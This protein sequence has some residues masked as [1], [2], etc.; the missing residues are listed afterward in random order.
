MFYSASL[1]LRQ[2]THSHTT[3]SDDHPDLIGD[4]DNDSQTTGQKDDELK[5]TPVDKDD[6]ET[7]N[8]SEII[9]ATSSEGDKNESMSAKTSDTEDSANQKSA[10]DADGTVLADLKSADDADKSDLAN[11]KSADDA[12]KPDLA[13]STEDGDEA[14]MA[15]RKSAVDDLAHQKS[16]QVTDQ[17][18]TE[19]QAGHIFLPDNITQLDTQQVS[20]EPNKELKAAD[21][22][23]K[24]S[25]DEAQAEDNIPDSL[26]P[27]LPDKPAQQVDEKPDSVLNAVDGFVELEESQTSDEVGGTEVISPIDT[28]VVQSADNQDVELA[29]QPSKESEAVDETAAVQADGEVIASMTGEIPTSDTETDDNNEQTQPESKPDDIAIQAMLANLSAALMQDYGD[30][31]DVNIDSPSIVHESHGDTENEKIECHEASILSVGDKSQQLEVYPKELKLTLTS[32]SFDMSPANAQTDQ[33]E[34]VSVSGTLPD[35]EI[36]DSLVIGSE[37]AVTKED[38]ENISKK[39]PAAPEYTDKTH[40]DLKQLSTE[41]PDN[42]VEPVQK[43]DYD[44][45]DELVKRTEV[46]DIPNAST[47]APKGT[48]D[49][50]PD[51]A[52]TTSGQPSTEKTV[53]AVVEPSCDHA[54]VTSKDISELT[55]EEEVAKADNGGS[56]GTPMELADSD[57]GDGDDETKAEYEDIYDDLYGELDNTAATA[58]TGAA[59]G[60]IAKG[61]IDL[62]QQ[63]AE[64]LFDTGDGQVYG[65][66]D[67]NTMA[68]VI[69][70]AAYDD[71]S[72]TGNSSQYQEYVDHS[73][74]HI[75][76][77]ETTTAEAPKLDNPEIDLGLQS[78]SWPPI[79]SNQSLT[80]LATP[81]TIQNPPMSISFSSG[82][83]HL[84]AAMQRI[85]EGEAPDLP[86]SFAYNPT[87]T[88]SIASS[89]ATTLSAEVVSTANSISPGMVLPLVSPSKVS[90]L[91]SPIQIQASTANLAPAPPLPSNIARVL[92]LNPATHVSSL[93][94]PPVP[95]N[96]SLSAPLTMPPVPPS[97]TAM[98]SYGTS[99]LPAPPPFP[100]MAAPPVMPAFVSAVGIS[101]MPTVSSAHRL[102][103]ELSIPL[104]PESIPL[105]PENSATPKA[106]SD[107]RPIPLPAYPVAV[108]ESL[109]SSHVTSVL[110]NSGDLISTCS[111]A[112]VTVTMAVAGTPKATSTMVSSSLKNS[113]ISPPLAAKNGSSSVRSVTLPTKSKSAQPV[114]IA[115][116]FRSGD[117]D[118]KPNTPPSRNESPDIPSTSSNTEPTKTPE[119]TDK[120]VSQSLPSTSTDLK[121]EVLS[122][123]SAPSILSQIA[124]T[125]S[126]IN[127]IVYT[128][129]AAQPTE[130]ENSKRSEKYKPRPKSKQAEREKKRKE[131]DRKSKDESERPSSRSS[132]HKHKNKSEKSHSEAGG[133]TSKQSKESR[134]GFKGDELQKLVELPKDPRQRPAELPRDP[135]AKPPDVVKTAVQE[136]VVQEVKAPNDAE[137]NLELEIA[138]KSTDPTKISSDAGPSSKL[139]VAK[140]KSKPVRRVSIDGSKIDTSATDIGELPV[141]AL[142]ARIQYLS[143]VMKGRAAKTKPTTVTKE[144]VPA[145]KA[146]KVAPGSVLPA[147]IQNVL[148]TI[149][150]STL[151]SLKSVITGK[152][153][154]S[155]PVIAAPKKIMST[156]PPELR[157]LKPEESIEMPQPALETETTDKPKL[158]ETSSDPSMEPVMPKCKPVL[159]AAELAA[160]AL[161]EAADREHI[162]ASR[163]EALFFDQVASE[164][165]DQEAST[166]GCGGIPGLTVKLGELMHLTILVSK[167][168]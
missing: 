65:E 69:H 26:H 72:L 67:T 93:Q 8:S 55:V 40:T 155:L 61:D 29:D 148:K 75:H 127:T 18:K 85:V 139:E 167:T 5:T 33:G 24:V 82:V 1:L 71:H 90:A 56:G 83:V 94:A 154:T 118:S 78:T 86:V 120:I 122:I 114:G 89:T 13:K 110:N 149:T 92:D 99:T 143:Q 62:R 58:S 59:K 68:A 30:K 96:I 103:I 16:N 111:D 144:Q 119:S 41:V 100:V 126:A 17:A 128:T 104:P 160:L 19:D 73:M 125:L 113:G 130:P 165:A 159:S 132:R 151:D 50:G 138:N 22:T 109:A 79:P 10:A 37:S 66:Q 145:Q 162:E 91:P 133:S 47:A 20:G 74:S 28:S 117:A 4:D 84:P 44:P 36:A 129:S 12:D 70:H 135:R 164:L 38:V 46:E 105:P 116:V 140:R 9:N 158:A 88:N 39:S 95:P 3:N 142:Q 107:S 80:L 168:K 31:M 27:A 77:A 141:E 81:A 21:N 97:L 57:S 14:D 51:L 48:L 121:A 11:K 32:E 25:T 153:T 131:K 34:S 147:A 136:K 43:L 101:S 45:I 157:N 15:N 115:S 161:E 152:N 150:P 102:P 7:M 64:D 98:S 76:E 60:D 2:H 166:S 134:G 156:V 49:T 106:L 23:T 52:L 112:S 87:P 35:V 53:A 163:K 54:D 124:A 108:P 146:E 123:E 137:T 42:P 63:C 6:P